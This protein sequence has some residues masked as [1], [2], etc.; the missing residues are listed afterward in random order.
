MAHA[1]AR[2][3]FEVE[4]AT[5]AN[6]IIRPAELHYRRLYEAL[7]KTLLSQQQL[8]HGDE[9][10]VQVLKEPRKATQSKAYMWVFRS[11]ED[12]PEPVVLFDYQPGRG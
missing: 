4:R 9:T 2:A 7:R 10:M 3:D 11:A 12:Y 6:W 1:L 5:L 8:I